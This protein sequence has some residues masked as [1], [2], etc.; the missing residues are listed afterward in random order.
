MVED[1]EVIEIRCLSVE[2]RQFLHFQPGL[3]EK[4]EYCRQSK[5]LVV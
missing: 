3:H 2:F 5:E 4:L 1:L